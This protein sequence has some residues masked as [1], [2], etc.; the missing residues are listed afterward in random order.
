MSSETTQHLNTQVLVGF[1][2][3]RGTA[4]H[5]KKDEQGD[6]PNHYTQAIPVEDVLRRLFAWHAIELPMFV[7]TSQGEVEVPNR[8]AIVRDDT[9][10]VLGVPSKAY[11][12]HQY[13][14]WLLTKVGNL[15]DDDLSIGS[16]GLLKGGAVV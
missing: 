1:T 9:F 3:Q 4:W 11:L 6:E 15:I 5:Y 14:E 10:N 2:D 13:D 12:P 7:H 16:A 8:K